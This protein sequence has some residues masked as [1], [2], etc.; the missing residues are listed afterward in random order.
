MLLQNAIS[1]HRHATELE[2]DELAAAPAQ[3]LMTEEDGALAFGGHGERYDR[4]QGQEDQYRRKDHEEVQ[5][6]PERGGEHASQMMV[7]HKNA[8]DAVSA[9]HG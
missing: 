1:V 8:P 2:N 7:A 3:S 6:P 5:R 4:H 9:R